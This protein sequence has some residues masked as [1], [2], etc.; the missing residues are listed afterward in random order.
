MN[1]TRPAPTVEKP[2]VDLPEEQAP[3]SR[4][5]GGE[6]PELGLVLVERVSGQ[7]T[8]V[9]VLLPDMGNDR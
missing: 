6:E 7:V 3:P 8:I 4:A 1:A 2:A 5:D 9:R